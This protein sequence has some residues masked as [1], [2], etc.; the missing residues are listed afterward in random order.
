MKKTN[1]WE[2]VNKESENIIK[3]IENGEIKTRKEYSDYLDS[4]YNWKISGSI[5]NIVTVYLSL[6][7]IDIPWVNEQEDKAE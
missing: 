7:D 2:L 3:A 5:A 4:I 1:V 6:N